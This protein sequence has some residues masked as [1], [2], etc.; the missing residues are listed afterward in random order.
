LPYCREIARLG[1]DR[2]A[3]LSPGRAAALN[4]KGG[5]IVN[6]AVATVFP[7]LPHS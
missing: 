7:D 5:R 2:F 1:L 3:T 6:A 4:M